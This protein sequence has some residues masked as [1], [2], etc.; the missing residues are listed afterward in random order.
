MERYE[1]TFDGGSRGNPGLAGAGW[2][3]WKY[4][5]DGRRR[6]VDAGTIYVGDNE[7]NNVSEYTGAIEL[8]EAALRYGV[9][10]LRVR[11][12]SK[13]V[14]MQVTNKWRVNA[15]HLLPLRN[16]LQELKAQFPDECT[17]EH[18]PRAANKAADG[19]SNL[20]MDDRRSFTGLHLL[21]RLE[22]S[23]R[24]PPP[25]VVP[26]APKGRAAKRPRVAK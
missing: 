15:E 10:S 11:G 8:C 17:F 2:V 16:R 21:E 20:A 18:I 26:S 1:G 9:R 6:R 19:M 5:D 25:I 24:A 23:A 12:D 4:Q 3:L 13:L 14:V 7:T 22:E